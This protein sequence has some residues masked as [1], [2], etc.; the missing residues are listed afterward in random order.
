MYV[1]LKILRVVLSITVFTLAGYGSI[2]GNHELIPYM[3]F[4][5]GAM[6][7]VIGISEIKEM[8]KRMGIF[9]ILVSI[10]VFYVFLERLLLN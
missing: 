5:M 7:L 4:F 1:L 6:F 10:F 3:L 2:S 8:R 9:S